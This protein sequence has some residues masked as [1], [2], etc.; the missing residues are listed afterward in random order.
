MGVRLDQ[1]LNLDKLS[2][3]PQNLNSIRREICRIQ[4]DLTTTLCNVLTVGKS[5]S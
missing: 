1:I 4:I 3:D 2:S 5:E